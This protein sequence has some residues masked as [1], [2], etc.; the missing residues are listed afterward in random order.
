MTKMTKAEA[1][2]KMMIVESY[3]LRLSARWR[4]DY[5][6]L[7]QDVKELYG[8]L[9]KFRYEIIAGTA[10]DQPKGSIDGPES[11]NRARMP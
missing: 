1:V 2:E 7:P 6:V 10:A 5:F 9:N 11:K 3:L 4:V 8:E